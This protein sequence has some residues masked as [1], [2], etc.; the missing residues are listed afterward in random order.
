MKK[1]IRLAYVEW[2]D[3]CSYEDSDPEDYEDIQVR[4]VPAK[5]AGFLLKDDD[6]GVVIYQTDFIG[7]LQRSTICIRKEYIIKK[8]VVRL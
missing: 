2:V 7:V 5:T 8:K 4:G 1:K 3:A 6:E